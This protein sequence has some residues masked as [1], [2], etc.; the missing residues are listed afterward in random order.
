KGGHVVEDAAGRLWGVDHGLSFNFEDKLRTVI[1]EFAGEPLG[2]GNVTRLEATRAGLGD[3]GLGE[4]LAALL[5]PEEA[6]AT[7]LRTEALL[8]SGVFPSPESRYRLPWPL[9]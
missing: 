4:E 2:E 8:S 3:G 9:V 5:S 6:S 1:W 7:L